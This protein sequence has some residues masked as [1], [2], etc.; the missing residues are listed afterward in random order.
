MDQLAFEVVDEQGQAVF[1][2]QE[3]RHDLDVAPVGPFERSGDA[4]ACGDDLVTGLAVSDDGGVGRS[5]EVAECVVG[6]VVGV[7]QRLDRRLTRPG[8]G[9]LEP[10]GPR[11]GPALVDDGHSTLAPQEAGVVQEPGPVRLD[12]G[13]DVVRDLGQPGVG[14]LCR[15]RSSSQTRIRPPEMV[16]ACPVIPS[17]SA[18]PRYTA[19]WA[20]S[21][22]WRNRP[23]GTRA[24]T[25]SRT[26]SG[27]ST[28]KTLCN[29]ADARS[30]MSVSTNPG[31]MAFTVTPCLAVS[32][33]RQRVSPTTACFDEL[34]GL[35]NS[36]PYL[37]AV[38][39][40]LTIFP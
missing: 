5:H 24:R 14:Y 19:R 28:P 1:E 23:C 20:I 32:R 39:A 17:D 16:R 4:G 18:D 12:V 37:P 25:I 40:T 31:Q 11:L 3:R 6:V 2:A 22:G 33:A 30:I 13:E 7:Y 15:H 36:E 9:L 34:Y 21:S 26:F 10:A 29:S 27:S 35:W 8:D 38:E